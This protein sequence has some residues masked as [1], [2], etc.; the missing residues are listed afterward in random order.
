MA[1]FAGP[2][3]AAGSTRRGGLGSWVLGA[4]FLLV[5]SLI[6]NFISS[7]LQPSPS[8]CS[9]QQCTLPPPKQGP[10]SPTN[11]YT[12]SRYGFTVD[13][14]TTNITPSKTSASSIAWDGTLSDNSDV[15]WSLTGMPASG[16]SAQQITESTQSSAYPDAQQAYVIPDAALGY[17]PGYGAVY[18]VTVSPANGQSQH[19][20]LVVVTAIRNGVAVV[21][22]GLGAYQSSGPG[23][24][25][26][27]NPADTPL[28]ELGDFEENINSVTWS[29]ERGF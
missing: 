27:P 17:T 8:S 1:V 18:D 16:R 19:D 24:S 22:V 4:V 3:P 21:L 11:H 5:L 6:F 14:S 20:R 26:Q 25:S 12:S 10:L 28:V 2:W 13:Y 9:S 29:G 23:S 15:S 7:I